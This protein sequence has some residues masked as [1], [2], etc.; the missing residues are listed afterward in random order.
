VNEITAITDPGA[1]PVA[2]L[3]RDG[4]A[5]GSVPMTETTQAGL[6]VASVPV[7]LAAGTYQVVVVL[8]QEIVGSGEL[9]WD[10]RREVSLRDTHERL[11][12][13]ATRTVGPDGEVGGGVDLTFTT[14]NGNQT[15]IERS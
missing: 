11:G 3:F 7:N 12:L 4:L 14:V 9:L 15:R 5:A 10:G 8:G 1:Q 2:R 6:Y 13:G